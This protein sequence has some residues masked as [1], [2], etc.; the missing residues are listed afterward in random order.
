MYFKDTKNT[1]EETITAIASDLKQIKMLPE[2]ASPWL[3]HSS[4][5]ELKANIQRA[6]HFNHLIIAQLNL[7][8]TSLLKGRI[9]QFRNYIES[10]LA[11]TNK[12]FESFYQHIDFRT[13]RSSCS[14][15]SYLKILEE[16]LKQ[17]EEYIHYFPENMANNLVLSL[18]EFSDIKLD[19]YQTA[20]LGL[21]YSHAQIKYVLIVARMENLAEKKRP[22]SS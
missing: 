19:L 11:L 10:D 20:H 14:L 22:I 3:I 12:L 7:I 5:F 8:K 13:N 18:S 2:N 4:F 6:V 17:I 15:K 21:Q 9:N 1:L 16:Q